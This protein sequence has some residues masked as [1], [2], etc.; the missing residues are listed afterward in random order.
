MGPNEPR[1][2]IFLVAR[3]HIVLDILEIVVRRQIQVIAGRNVVV[4]ELSSVLDDTESLIGVVL[5]SC[6]DVNEVL[7]DIVGLLLQLLLL[8]KFFC[9]RFVV[10]NHPRLSLAKFSE[11][12]HLWHAISATFSISSKS[13]FNKI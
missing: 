9:K 1:L 6:L 7:L 10:S 8:F 11:R 4:N 12:T 3:R 2:R 5:L 13:F